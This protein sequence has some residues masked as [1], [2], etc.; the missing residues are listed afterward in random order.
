ML[1]VI[2]LSHPDPGIFSDNNKRIL[3][4]LANQIAMAIT[5]NSILRAEQEVSRNNI[6]WAISSLVETN[7]RLKMVSDVS[8][9]I[10]S[11][12]DL[13]KTLNV[14]LIKVNE[15]LQAERSSIL[16]INDETGDLV[17]ETAIGQGTEN[18]P[19]TNLKSGES[20]SGHVAETGKPILVT[21][22]EKDPR[23]MRS[24]RP[25][26]STKSLISVPLLSKGRTIGVLNISDK[27]DKSSFMENDLELVTALAS[28][29]SIAIQ[30]ASMFERKKQTVLELEI[31]SDINEKIQRAR[32]ISNAM[33]MIMESVARITNFSFSLFY[34][35]NPKKH[36][37][38][39]KH[40][41]GI[42]SAEAWDYKLIFSE[43]VTSLIKDDPSELTR[44]PEKYFGNITK[45]PKVRNA[46]HKR[47]IPFVVEEKFFGLL[48]ICK[49]EGRDFT[50][51]DLNFLQII[52]SQAAALYE[53]SL[54]LISASQLITLGEIMGSAMH[55]LKNPLTAIKGTIQL[56]VAK[57]DDVALTR[58][59]LEVMN[60][61][62]QHLEELIDG[63]FSI[64]GSH[65]THFQAQNINTILRKL[66]STVKTRFAR[67][68]IN[69][70]MDLADNIPTSI[71]DYRQIYEALL[72]IL[73]NALQAMEGKGGGAVCIS[74]R[75]LE[76]D[77]DKELI[78]IRIKDNGPGISKKH[79]EKIF[80]RF[81]T[82]KEN[83]TGLGLPLVQQIVKNHMGEIEVVSKVNEGTEFIIKLPV[84]R[85]KPKTEFA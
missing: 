50:K 75:L 5:N 33:E 18:L 58:K 57:G 9:L 72:N 3:N 46:S 70:T 27:T 82:T 1:G 7:R 41:R 48:V 13:D 47:L 36:K 49:N 19:D 15:V 34:Y 65:M 76:V 60:N 14:I 69:I 55:D 26:Y 44:S 62:V 52:A 22:I 12:L 17:I 11:S 32:N 59:G 56:L 39:L 29:I 68:H 80:E 6:S 21:D 20:I 78:E 16:L 31:L 28:Q 67:C 81:F 63:Y 66:Q 25:C 42:S 30:N 71:V 79:Q 85:E 40:Y 84:S 37:L 73:I 74:T 54:T 24:N 38:S 61:S 51:R 83:G 77:Y 10:S 64:T 4:M 53:R 35:W 8:R 2:N 23:V 45:L 43:K